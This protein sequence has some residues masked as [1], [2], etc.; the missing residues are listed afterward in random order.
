MQL[1]ALVAAAPHGKSLSHRD[2]A[3]EQKTEP[4]VLNVHD[5][6]LLD[7]TSEGLFISSSLLHFCDRVFCDFVTD[8]T[9]FVSA[10]MF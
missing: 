7:E 8:T 9:K 2:Q 1:C 4:S 3:Q 5:F 6:E 10:E